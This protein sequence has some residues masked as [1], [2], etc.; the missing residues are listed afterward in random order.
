MAREAV[1][2][3]Q[4]LKVLYASGYPGEALVQG[5]KLERG[6]VLLHKP[7]DEGELAR[8]VR[9]VLDDDGVSVL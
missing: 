3:R 7:Y 1:R 4:G 9:S 6:A 8:K 2:R 5:G